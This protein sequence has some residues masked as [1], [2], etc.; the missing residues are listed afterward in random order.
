MPRRTKGLEAT[1]GIPAGRLAA[2]GKLAAATAHDVRNALGGVALRVR[3]LQ[4]ASGPSLLGELRL[5]ERA[6]DDALAALGRLQD[7]ARGGV[8]RTART[9]NLREV[10]EDAAALALVPIELRLP[11]T[12]PRVKGC[13]PA[14]RHVFLNLLLN[15]R[16]AAGRAR[17]AARRSGRTVI[18]AVS[19][20]GRGIPPEHLPHVFEPDFSTKGAR[21]GLGLALVRAELER[22]G[23][24]IS[25][26]NAPGGGA[27]FT[28]RLPVG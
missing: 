22:I 14:L 10:V 21:G 3:L 25:A 27:V 13:P 2:I 16:D 20:E 19:D 4:Q 15:A 18:V 1:S 11:T 8:G 23:G 9:S 5:I 6:L 17:I 7:T 24:S 12:L 26:A 28:L